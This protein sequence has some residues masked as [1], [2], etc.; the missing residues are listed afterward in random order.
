MVILGYLL[1]FIQCVISPV[2][3]HIDFIVHHISVLEDE[4]L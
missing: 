2:E 4:M 3:I 1:L